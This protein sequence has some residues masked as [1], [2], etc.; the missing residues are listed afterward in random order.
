M[1]SS[2]M[3]HFLRAQGREAFTL[4]EV[5]MAATVMALG[6]MGMIQVVISGSEML[7][8]ARKQTIAT[9]ILRSEIDNL[10]L[11]DWTTQVSQFPLSPTTT[12]ITINSS[13]Q[14][15]SQGFQ[16]QREVWD[17]KADHTLRKV[18][19]TVTWTSN[20]GRAYARSGSTY[21]GKN[22]LYVAYQ[23]S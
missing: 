22:G 5:M 9:Q 23:R 2:V 8:V 7:D 13:F 4:I 6:I 20:T 1:G 12:P 17:V 21:F 18:K 19:F 3:N 15:I 11:S 16:C 10:H 14:T